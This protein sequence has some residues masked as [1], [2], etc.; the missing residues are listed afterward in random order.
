MAFAL[1]NAAPAVPAKDVA[2]LLLNDGGQRCSDAI[3]MSRM[4][5]VHQGIP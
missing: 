1:V 4:S 3:P 2:Y 5:T